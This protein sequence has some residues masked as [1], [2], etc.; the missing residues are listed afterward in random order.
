MH[1]R[2]SIDV[3]GIGKKTFASSGMGEVSPEGNKVRWMVKTHKAPKFYESTIKLNISYST[4]SGIR[5]RGE[6]SF[7]LDR[8][9]AVGKSVQFNLN[10]RIAVDERNIT[11][12]SMT[13]SPTA[14]VITGQIQNV[15]E[16]GIDHLTDNR[17]YPELIEMELYANGVQVDSQGSGMSTNLNG[18]NFTLYF[19]RLPEEVKKLQLKLS[20]F[21]A[22][23]QVDEKVSIKEGESKRLNING[24]TIEIEKVFVKDNETYIDIRTDE[25]TSLPKVNLISDG[26][27]VELSETIPGDYEKVID[28]QKVRNSYRR[29]LKFLGTV[30]ELSLNI[31]KIR[32]VKDMDITVFSKVK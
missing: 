15:V 21:T 32:F 1:S 26:E 16:L 25:N 29:T 30:D 27:L 18:I 31:G 4:K 22:T 9:Q 3:V 17:L 6:I 12:K 8:S 11:V 2:I 28:G 7:K 5:E 19:D 20:S 24:Q 13:A 23:I 10:R 14:T